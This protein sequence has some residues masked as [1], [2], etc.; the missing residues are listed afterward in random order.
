MIGCDGGCE[1]WF[2]LSCI[3]L[4][5]KSANKLDSYLCSGCCARLLEP[6][7]ARA[8][9]AADAEAEA[10]EAAKQAAKA[11]R[12]RR[13]SCFE[14]N[15]A[16]GKKQPTRRSH[17]ASLGGPL[18]VR[19]KSE[20]DVCA[21]TPTPAEAPPASPELCL[22]DFVMTSRPVVTRPILKGRP[23]ATPVTPATPASTATPAT[24]ATP[25]STADGLAPMGIAARPRAE[26]ADKRIRFHPQTRTRHF[27]RVQMG[28]CSVPRDGG[29][30][31]G[32]DWA[33]THEAD[34][35][36]HADGKGLELGL[37]ESAAPVVRRR[38]PCSKASM[39]EELPRLSEDERKEVLEDAGVVLYE[40]EGEELAMIRASRGTVL[41]LMC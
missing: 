41:L 31:M 9:A 32:L 22:D 33:W 5:Q 18:V 39:A 6:S 10:H 19:A 24:P 3:G 34:T 38:H 36:L 2:H 7:A 1:N 15:S 12:R 16:L 13:R 8:K 17:R 35:Q 40:G 14:P 37:D 29:C 27:A 11:Q 23:P 25:A 30:S 26:A 28:S 20:E 21:A 4:S